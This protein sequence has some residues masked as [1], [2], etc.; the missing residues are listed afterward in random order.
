[1]KAT[2]SNKEKKVQAALSYGKGTW[3]T[4]ECL[5]PLF[6]RGTDKLQDIPDR[7]CSVL[8]EEVERLQMEI[9]KMKKRKQKHSKWIKEMSERL[10]QL[11][12]EKSKAYREKKVETAR[13]LEKDYMQCR[14]LVNSHHQNKTAKKIAFKN[15]N[16]KS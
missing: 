12:K 10:H 13:Q 1:M 4:L 11:K 2:L 8:A 6:S 7:A 16:L 3:W 9:E 15:L 5:S 14:K